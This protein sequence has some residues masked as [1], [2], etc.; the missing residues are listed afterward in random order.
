MVGSHVGAP[1][2]HTTHRTHSLAFRA[3]TALFGH[4]GIEWDLREACDADLDELSAWVQL[5]KDERDL[6]HSGTTVR[7]D[8]PDDTYWAHGVVS[9]DQRR[10]LFAFAALDTTPAAQPDRVRLPGLNPDAHYRVEI[11]PLSRAALVDTRSGCPSWLT[12]RHPI[13][14]A[15]LSTI[16]LQGPMLYPEQVLLFRLTADHATHLER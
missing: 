10:A 4:F 9:R 13:S 7:S 6:L 3:G 11:V 1:T 5:Y 8:Y 14:G 2:A 15:A 12:D 16:G